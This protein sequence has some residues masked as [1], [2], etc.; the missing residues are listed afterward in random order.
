MVAVLLFFIFKLKFFLPKKQEFSVRCFIRD[1]FKFKISYVCL[2]MTPSP[3]Y[4]EKQRLQFCLIHTVNNILQ[5]NEFTAAKMDE[6]CYEFNES[7]W[8]NPHKSWIGTGNYDANILMAALQKHDLKVMWFDKRT[9][10][11][12]VH[13]ENVKALVFNI[14]S[15]TLLTLYR[16]RHWFAVMEKHG[17]LVGESSKKS[18]YEGQLV[19]GSL[20][21]LS[22]NIV[23]KR[24]ASIHNW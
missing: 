15:R 8:F 20:V 3:I 10:V 5:K 24:F 4:H 18:V 17:K 16:G 1:L 12:K 2:Q 23:T 6:I 7:K 14:P 19:L 21:P 22:Q 11:E 9:P 13:L